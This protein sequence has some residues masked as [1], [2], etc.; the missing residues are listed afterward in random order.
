MGAA[1]AIIGLGQGAFTM[2]QASKEVDALNRQREYMDRMSNVNKMFNDN[3]AK[4]AIARGDEQ[5]SMLGRK[6]KQL[7]GTQRVNLAAQGIEL[8]SG[9]ALDIQQDTAKLSKIDEIKIRNNAW[10]EAWG[11]KTQG[12]L[13]DIQIKTNRQALINKGQSTLT[14]GGIQAATQMASGFMR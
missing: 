3:L 6:T 14:T 11:I 8:D 7:I 4:E 13:Q 1:A 12:M 9:S 2:Y 10:K 5:A